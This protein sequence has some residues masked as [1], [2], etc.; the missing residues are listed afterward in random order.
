M[1]QKSFSV[2]PAPDPRAVA[3]KN[4]VAAALIYLLARRR[5]DR[6]RVSD[7]V[8]AA[9]VGR[10]TFYRH[11][12]ARDALLA[13]RFAFVLQAMV[14]PSGG[15]GA[16]AD[17][18]EFFDHVRSAPYIWRSLMTGAARNSAEPVLRSTLERFFAPESASGSNSRQSV[19][20]PFAAS[21]LLT[22]LAWWIER[23]H[24]IPPSRLQSIYAG[25]MGSSL[26][27]RV[28]D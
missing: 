14:R 17:F 9:R 19:L 20:A 10:A 23:G 5:Y 15:Q 18:T 13:E 27:S 26:K 21:T 6:I 8:R 4:R 22:V 3:T 1:K 2:S 11:Y 24:D 25:L 7:I 16:C 12:R 28:L